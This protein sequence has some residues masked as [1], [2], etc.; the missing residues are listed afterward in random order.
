MIVLYTV[1]RDSGTYSSGVNC[2][3]RLGIMP[4]GRRKLA[5]RRHAR[6]S[7]LALG[8]VRLGAFRLGETGTFT[9][10]GHD[11]HMGPPSPA[12]AAGHDRLKCPDFS[13]SRG[14][15]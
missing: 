13:G 6:Y 1:A 15:D 2:P 3:P 4:E 12:S 7:I 11:Q 14:F 5:V 10:Q 8:N 9:T